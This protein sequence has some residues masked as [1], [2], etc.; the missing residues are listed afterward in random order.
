MRRARFILPFKACAK[1]FLCT[2]IDNVI[3][4]VTPKTRLCV[5]KYH[6]LATMVPMNALSKVQTHFSSAIPLW[7]YKFHLR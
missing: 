5:P 6:V 7:D 3:G 4:T 2:K 1:T